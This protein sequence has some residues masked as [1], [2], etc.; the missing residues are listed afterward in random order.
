MLSPGTRWRDKLQLKSEKEVLDWRAWWLKRGQ[1]NRRVREGLVEVCRHD[2]L[3]YINLFVWQYN[4]RAIKYG[5][6][7]VSPFITWPFQDHDFLFI[8]KCIEDQINLVCEKSRDMGFSWM[9][10]IVAD[11][12]CRFHSNKKVLVVSRGEKA[13]DS[14]SDDAL[15][16]RI[17]FIHEHLPEWL[18][19][20]VKK[21]KLHFA[22]PNRSS[23]SG[24]AT[25]ASAGVGG[26]A[27]V[28]VID[29]FCHVEKDWEMLHRT[30]DTAYCRIFNSTHLGLGTAFFKLCN[31]RESFPARRWRKLQRHWT[32]HPMKNKGLY[33]FNPARNQIEIL[34]QQNP[35]PP[36]Y[37]FIRTEAPVGG[38]KPGVRSPWYDDACADKGNDRAIAM[39]L[40]INPQGSVSQVFSPIRIAYLK[41][42][43]CVPP[44]WQGDVKFHDK[45]GAPLEPIELVKQDKGPLRM[46]IHPNG[47]QVRKSKYKIG[48]DLSTGRGATNSCVSITDASLG[49][50]VASYT[51]PDVKPERLAE[52]V[53]LLGRMFRDEEDREAE[54]A[55][56]CPGPGLDF[57]DVII[58]L[59]YRNFYCRSQQE[60]SGPKLYDRGKAEIP[61][62]FQ[63]NDGK[64]WLIDRYCRAVEGKKYITRDED[65]LEEC[66]AFK[67]SYDGRTVEHS[68]DTG[69]DPSGARLN[70]GDRV[71]AAALS[72]MLAVDEGGFIQEEKKQEIPVGSLAWRRQL[73]EN[74][75]GE[76]DEPESVWIGGREWY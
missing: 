72:W 66:L 73:W 48:V 67:W 42:E 26:R 55:W 49:E 38:P 39:D 13:V 54:L 24:E 60:R 20:E 40:D 31:D 74:S 28:M 27:T 52:I 4:P 46:W 19:G 37:E 1:A 43:L 34:D 69:E 50:K 2:I 44:Y 59:G 75:R 22:Y 36:D 65:E 18:Q 3:W 45:T 33:R 71:I 11:W 61:G 9:H 16:P 53:V 68:G 57:G 41:A 17:E 76:R 32:D 12:L 15:F 8:L 14:A 47:N 63:S 29:E 35:P 10:L 25:T 5:Q 7:E 6:P 58:R 56:E 51:T 21:Q 23:I 62:W 30:S 70:H 64:R